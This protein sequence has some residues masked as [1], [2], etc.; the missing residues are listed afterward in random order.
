MAALPDLLRLFRLAAVLGLIPLIRSCD[1]TGMAQTLGF[2]MPVLEVWNVNYR[3]ETLHGLMLAI[4]VALFAVLAAWL[5]IKR[6]AQLKRLG[7]WRLATVMMGV[8]AF[9]F[10]VGW[11]M[12]FPLLPV[13]LV[14]GSLTDWVS[15]SVWFDVLSRLLLAGIVWLAMTV[16]VPAQRPEPRPD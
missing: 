7:H 10:I 13:A 14:L 15:F 1:D 11:V 3:L 16:L 12:F 9:N 4:N 2:P 6:P 8:A 5:W